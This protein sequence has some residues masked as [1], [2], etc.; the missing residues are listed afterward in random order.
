[1]K[2]SVAVLF[3]SR[4]CEHDVSIITGIQ[5]LGALD[6]EQYDAFPV[7]IARDGAWYVGERLK[8]ISFYPS[9]DPAQARKVLPTADGGRL[10]LIDPE[11][12]H[13]LFSKGGKV[14]ASADVALLALHG[15]NGEDGTLQGMLEMMDVPYTSS[16]VMGS[17]VGMDKIAMKQLFKSCGF[18]VLPDT[19]IDRAAWKKDRAACVEKIEAAL[20]YPVYVK[21]ANLGSSIGIKRANDRKGLEEALDVAASFDRRILVEKG[22]VVRREV[23]CSVL[24]YGEEVRASELEMPLGGE[25]LVDFNDKYGKR[26]K[27]GKGM[28]SLARLIPAPVPEETAAR[29]KALSLDI[30]RAL[31]CKGV[32]RIDFLLDGED[33]ALYVGEINT[34]PGSLAF[35]LWEPV[36]LAFGKLLDEMIRCALTAAADRRE[37]VFSYKSDILKDQ[38]LAASRARADPVSQSGPDTNSKQ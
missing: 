10:L 35:Y 29:I 22:V 14:L 20:E 27:G 11:P 13:G 16:G 30:F 17:S 34:I 28:Q 12:R 37:S 23:N 25:E 7:Y 24:G 32:V 5:A 1:M 2:L 26:A 6:P 8:D 9:F 33:D 18:P 21:P 3:G 38:K 36:G 15:M 19:W 4:T 31:D